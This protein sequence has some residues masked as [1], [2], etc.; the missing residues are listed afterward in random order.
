M[1][2][3]KRF[4][5]L[6]KAWYGE[7]NLR[8]RKD[9]C[10]EALTFGTYDQNGSCLA[11]ASFEWIPLGREILPTLIVM[12]DSWNLFSEASEFFTELAKVSARNYSVE[13]LARLLIASGFLDAT[14]TEGP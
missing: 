3:E 7:A 2:I 11:E 13:N 14:P 10:R 4:V 6:S 8:A 5:I 9:G 12:P 1:G